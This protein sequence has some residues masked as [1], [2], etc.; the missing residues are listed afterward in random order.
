RSINTEKVE[1]VARVPNGPEVEGMVGLKNYLLEH[2]KNDIAENILRR[3]LSYGIGRKLT[4]HDR[5]VV[6]ELIEGSAVNDYRLL[7][8]IIAICQSRVFSGTASK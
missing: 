5:F 3:L 4:T 2:R 8:M 1:A 7:D 6:G